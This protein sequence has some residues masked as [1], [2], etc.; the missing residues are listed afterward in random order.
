[1]SRTLQ[2]PFAPGHTWEINNHFHDRETRYLYEGMDGDWSA[3]RRV[4]RARGRVNGS[5]RRMRVPDA[6]GR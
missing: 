6:G 5:P 2:L 3:T 1:M 4:R